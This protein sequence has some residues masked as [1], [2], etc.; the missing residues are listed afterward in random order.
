MED[1]KRSGHPLI[2]EG[3]TADNILDGRL[4]VIQKER[5]Y[6]FSV[7]ALLLAYFVGPGKGR[8]LDLGTGSGIIALILSRTR[9]GSRIIAIE[10]QKEMAEMARRTLSL[11]G[12]GDTIEI[13][14]G[15]I[16]RI[17]DLVPS[18]SMDLVVAN[19]PYRRLRSGRINPDSE[20]ALARHEISGALDD[21]LKAAAHALIPGG[22]ICLVYPAR[23]MVDLICRMRQSRLEPKRCRLVH[24]TPASRG[25]FILAEGVAG[26]R[27]ELLVEPP[28]YIYDPG[29]AYSAAMTALF[30]DLASSPGSGDDRSP[31][32]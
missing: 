26:G 4:R 32:S 10:I 5:G 22:R 11:N 24:S 18:R 15:D 12:I 9:P 21:F 13:L 19:P 6:R 25:E 3:E 1:E 28:L 31:S 27:E 2:K 7:D 23:R 8:L 17:G 16:R 20:K 14:T 29:G 30:S